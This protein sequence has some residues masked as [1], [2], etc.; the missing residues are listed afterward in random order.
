MDHGTVFNIQRFSIHDGPGIRTTVFLKGCPLRCSWCHNPEGISP[1]PEL[2]V[3]IRRCIACGECLG[4]CPS[5]LPVPG[6]APQPN[7]L[8]RCLAC[9]ACAMACPCEARQIVGEEMSAAAVLEEIVKDRVFFEESGGGVTFSGGEPLW[10]ADFLARL[11]KACKVEGI[12]TVVDTCGQ[13]PWRDLESVTRLTD[14]FLYDIKLM[15]DRMHR[16]HTGASNG[17]ILENL[18]R[19]ARVHQKIW[20]RVP[21]IPGVNDSVVNMQATAR[22]AASLPAVEK[23]CLLP[24]HPL[25]EDK[26]R[27]QGRLPLDVDSP[28]PSQPWLDRLVQTVEGAGIPASLG[29]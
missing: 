6:V 18:Y 11:L 19:L 15:D 16:A 9:G 20:L 8:E 17:R 14:L 2:A 3:S 5:S 26:N 21:I 23:V 28:R 10:Q 24:F 29:G 1:K 12:H 4:S 27:R 22:M 25:G 7:D 13:V